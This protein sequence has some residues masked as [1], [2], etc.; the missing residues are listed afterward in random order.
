M[1][2]FPKWWAA[3][4]FVLS[5]PATFYWGKLAFIALLV[6]ASFQLMLYGGMRFH[7]MSSDSHLHSL[8]VMT[9]NAG[10]GLL[11]LAKLKSFILGGS[12]DL[13]A[14]QELPKEVA[15]DL[16]LTPPDWFLLRCGKLVIASRYPVELVSSLERN[17]IVV[18]QGYG[19]VYMTF[20]VKLPGRPMRFMNVHL[21]TP[22][23]G[24]E[25]FVHRDFDLENL[26]NN[27]RRRYHETTI[28]ANDAK[29]MGVSVVLGDFNMPYESPLYQ[30]YF[31]DY[32]NAFSASGNGFGSTKY[33][34]WYS[35]R[36]DHVLLT[37]SLKPL[38]AKVGLDLGSDHRPLL[39]DLEFYE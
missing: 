4:L 19:L 16:I 3:V 29:S 5:L 22:R 28:V 20:D 17:D 25:P 32:T 9:L 11:D 27:F 33:T 7:P 12:V 24:L 18:G 21:D 1:L 15:I 26:R 8:Q 35:V 13:I 31:G 30:A 37:S 14:F 6:C 23:S 10:E 2:F 39:V 34:S 36:I 38:Q